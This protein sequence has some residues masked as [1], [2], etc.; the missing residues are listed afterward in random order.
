MRESR[1]N[2]NPVWFMESPDLQNWPRI[3]TTN[4]AFRRSRRLSA[5]KGHT[6]VARGRARVLE[7]DYPG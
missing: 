5:L 2:E 7:R 6:I 1:P 4:L 3:G